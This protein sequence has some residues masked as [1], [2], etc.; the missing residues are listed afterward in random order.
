MRVVTQENDP[1]AA[2]RFRHAAHRVYTAD[3]T[4]AGG[5]GTLGERMLHAI[6]KQYLSPDEATH[7]VRI[8]RY[9]ADVCRGDEILEIQTRRLDR[10]RAK[11]D[12]F[13]PDHIVTVVYPVAVCKTVAWLDPVSGEMTPPRKSPKRGSVYDAFYELY[14]LRDYLSHP[15][16]RFRVILTDMEE[17]RYLTGGGR[18]R[19]R[20]APR[21]ERIP[22]ALVAD[23]TWETP[24]D[25]AA[26]LPPEPLRFTTGELA[27]ALHIYP[28]A[29]QR[30]V[31][32][33]RET[34]AIRAVGKS[35]RSVL[36]AREECP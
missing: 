11:L 15:H 10:L 23:Y 29:A 32:I 28:T 17:F 21:A 19:K 9:V 12:A 7:E 5:I 26:I 20:H 16:F 35:A 1:A 14:A 6:L 34:G 36:Y 13:L 31:R 4:A 25:Y 2:E 18:D 22:T 30:Y 24:A 3:R 8:G 33:L 27:K